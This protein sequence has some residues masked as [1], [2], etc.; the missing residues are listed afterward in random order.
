MSF[1]Q[2]SIMI[3]CEVCQANFESDFLQT[4]QFGLSDEQVL[5]KSTHSP[6]CAVINPPYQYSSITTETSDDPNMAIYDIH[7]VQ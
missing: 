4:S 1:G 5:T 3:N 6:Q 7:G 2:Y